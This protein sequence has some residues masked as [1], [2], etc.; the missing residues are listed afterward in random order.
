MVTRRE[1]IEMGEKVKG[2]LVNKIVI[3]FMVTD[4]YY[5]KWG[6]HIARYKSFESLYCTNMVSETNITNMI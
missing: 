4:D 3:G 6:D 1:G 2:L 5:I